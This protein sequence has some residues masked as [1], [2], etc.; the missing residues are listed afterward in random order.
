MAQLGR[1]TSGS[2]RR[3]PLLVGG[4][5]ALIV[6]IGAFL[7]TLPDVGAGLWLDYVIAPLTAA[8]AVVVVRRPGA[9][10]GWV[11][12]LARLIVGG[13]WIWA[14]LLKLPDAAASIESVRA[15]DLLPQ[16]W[17]EPVGYLLPVLEIVLGLALVLG[18]MTRGAALLSA[19]LLVVFVVAIST[20]WAR[21]LKIDCGCF[22]D[23]GANPDA[24]QQY[25]WEIARD[26]G[27]VALSFFV[28]T[29]RQSRFALDSVLFGNRLS[30]DDFLE[31][32]DT[33]DQPE[34]STA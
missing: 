7:V 28:L 24:A 9:I 5:L 8:L 2:V 12:L 18:L 6:W 26:G 10:E 30:L 27:L 25:P 4:L 32:A 14:G 21:G 22:G 33:A 3:R 15:Y 20:A 19:L 34:G 1:L 31:A 11:S 29:L 23:G 17:V 13:I 16:A